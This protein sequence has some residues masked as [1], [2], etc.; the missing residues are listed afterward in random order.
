MLHNPK[1]D[2]QGITDLQNLRTDKRPIDPSEM[3][4]RAA[5]QEETLSFIGRLIGSSLPV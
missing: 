2:S 1:E 5:E 4:K 3:A